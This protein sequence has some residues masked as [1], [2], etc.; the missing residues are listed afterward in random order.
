MTLDRLMGL[1]FLLTA[2]AVPAAAADLT[3]LLRVGDAHDAERRTRE[4]LAA[5]RQ[6]ERLAPGRADILHRISKQLGESIYDTP[7]PAQRRALTEQ[8]LNYA[9]RAVAA[10]PQSSDA[11]IA[12]AICLGLMTPNQTNKEKIAASRLIKSHAERALALNPDNELAHYV[13]GAWHYGLA[14]LNPVL[15][16]LARVIY[17]RLPPASLEEAAR[18]FRSALVLNPSRAAT[19]LGLGATLARQ[20]RTADAR[21]A[22]QKAVALPV[23]YKDDP[24]TQARARAA[25]ADLP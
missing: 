11:Q 3:T 16:S 19:W 2:L 6:A 8:A 20:G 23:R 1:L 10:D 17:G 18:H 14:S 4:A 7:D 15:A 9:R 24:A 22:Y 25:L 5:Y 12:L 21:A 13:L